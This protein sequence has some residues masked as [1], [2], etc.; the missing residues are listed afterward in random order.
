[1]KRF[2]VSWQKAW[3]T[4][5]ICTWV[6]YLSTK[7]FPK[8][9]IIWAADYSTIFKHDLPVFFNMTFL[10]FFPVFFSLL[11]WPHMHFSMHFQHWGYN[12]TLSSTVKWKTEFFICRLPTQKTVAGYCFLCFSWWLSSNNYFHWHPYEDNRWWD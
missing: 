9:V 8:D 11:L 12:M 6:I 4:C 2:P 3:T 10:S 7:A 1:M 5:F